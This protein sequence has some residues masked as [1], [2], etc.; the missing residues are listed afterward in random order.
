MEEDLTDEMRAVVLNQLL[1]IS[2]ADNKRLI[3]M[4]NKLNTMV[5]ELLDVKREQE[6][7]IHHLQDFCESD[8]IIYKRYESFQ[9]N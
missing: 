8:E 6:K 1:D 9:E 4:V 5:T 7:T 2:L 3:D